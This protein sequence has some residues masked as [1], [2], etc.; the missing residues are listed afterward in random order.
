MTD[1]HHHELVPDLAHVARAR[2]IVREA[3]GERADIRV[4]T[5]VS[6]V[7]SNAIKAHRADGNADPISLAIDATGG[8]VEVSNASDW[9]PALPDAPPSPTSPAGRGLLVASNLC[10]GLELL[11]DGGMVT[12]RLPLPSSDDAV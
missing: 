3:V 9:T 11:A 6:E 4:L 12:V 5:A 2:E 8:W 1:S 7:V 10:P